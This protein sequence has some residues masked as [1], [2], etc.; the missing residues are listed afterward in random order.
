MQVTVGLKRSCCVPTKPPSWGKL[1]SETSEP[2][3]VHVCCG[4]MLAWKASAVLRAGKVPREDGGNHGEG[5]HGHQL[6]TPG[7]LQVDVEPN[8]TGGEDACR[9][10]DRKVADEGHGVAVCAG[11][12]E[13]VGRD[14]G[15]LLKIPPSEVTEEMQLAHVSCLLEVYC[16]ADVL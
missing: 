8:H 10:Q 3:F 6:W 14:S 2:Q 5:S 16:V 12:G 1:P 7:A 13:N 11:D 9:H 4:E 15:E